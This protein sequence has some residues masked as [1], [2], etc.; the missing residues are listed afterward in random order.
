VTLTATDANGNVS[1]A[2]AIVKIE[3]KT[4]PVVATKNIIVQLDATGNA[5]ILASNVDNGSADSC[6]TPVLTVSPNTFTCANVGNNT[7]T[8]TA[9]DANGNVASKTVIVTIENKNAPIALAKNTLVQLNATGNATITAADVNNG[10]TATCGTPVLTVS[11]STFTCANVGANTVTLTVTDANGNVSLATAIVTVQDKVAPVVLVKNATVQLD[12][13]GNASITASQ[14]DNGSSDTCGIASI[15]VTPNTFSCNNVG[16]NQV[17]LKVTDV[18][19]NVAT[20]TATVTVG[21][22]ILPTAKTRN[23]SVQLDDAGNASV[24]VNEINNGSSDNCGI[25]SVSVSKLS[26]DCTNVGANTVI[27]TVT[28]KN[29]NKSTA[30]AIVTVT[31]TFGDNDNDGILD[32]CDADDDNDGISD[33]IDNCPITANPYQEDRNHN[34]LGDACDKDQMNISEAFTP[35]GDGINDTWVISNIENHPSSVVRVFNRWGAEVFVARNYQND[36]DG[37]SKGNSSTLPAA[38]SYYYQIDLD[39]NGTIDK[40]GWIYI[41]R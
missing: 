23:L 11:P 16:V 1:S 9:T 29:G 7:V 27:L 26:F 19:G 4:A 28:D 6:G 21:D 10:S 12:A 35:N 33:A 37:H 30:T 36:W 2:T 14:I 18:N 41:N 32:N 25:A 39:G 3:D 38:S 8:L 40:Q 24:T 15:T 20:A 13:S 34:G 17:T 5:S 31:N 22:L